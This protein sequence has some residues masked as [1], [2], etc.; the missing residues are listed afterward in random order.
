MGRA[1]AVFDAVFCRNVLIYFAAR[2]RA[3]AIARLADAL[4]PGG[5][6]FLGPCETGVRL[7]ATFARIGPAAYRKD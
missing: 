5:L 3:G 6:F 7:P 4:R 2:E 1:R